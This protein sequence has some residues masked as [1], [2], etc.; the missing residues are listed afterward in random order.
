[1]ESGPGAGL[2]EWLP[3]VGT[4]DTRKPCFPKELEQVRTSC[5][6]GIGI[7]EALVFVKDTRQDH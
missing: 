7:Q 4:V 3:F 2:R 6:P 5:E 1:M